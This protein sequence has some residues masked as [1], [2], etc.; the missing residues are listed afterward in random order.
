MSKT[1]FNESTPNFKSGEQDSPYQRAKQSWDDRLGTAYGQVRAWRWVAITALALA[2][3][4]LSVLLWFINTSHDKVFIAQVTKAGQV[5]NVAPLVRRITPTQAEVEYFLKEFISNMRSLPL[6]PVLAKQHWLKAYHFLSESGAKTFN[7]FMQTAHPEKQLGKQ[8]V[9]V[10]INDVNPMSQNT[11]AIDWQET[12]TSVDKQHNSV[13]QYSGVFTLAFK[14]P[15]NQ[16][17]ILV[18]PL[19]L[20]I[21]DFHLSA[22]SDAHA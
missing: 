10:K 14:S 20:Y 7:Q 22:R 18:N 16:A 21:I 1:P 6:D 19:G 4:S 3:V 2:S 17:D 11:Y 8:T 9:L 13:K 5:V 15:K 12:I